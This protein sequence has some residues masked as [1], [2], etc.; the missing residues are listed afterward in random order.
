MQRSDLERNGSF[1]LVLK[2][3]FKAAMASRRVSQTILSDSTH[4]LSYIRINAIGFLLK[5]KDVRHPE[6]ITDN[7]TNDPVFD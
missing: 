4:L 2:L 3:K 6:E 7:I 1:T 5:E